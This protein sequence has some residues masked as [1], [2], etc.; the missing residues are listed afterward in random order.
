MTTASF[1]PVAASALLFSGFWGKPK[2]GDSALNP[3]TILTLSGTQ[4]SPGCLA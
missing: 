2:L 4:S 1:S 3:G